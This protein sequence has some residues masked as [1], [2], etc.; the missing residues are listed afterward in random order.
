MSNVRCYP[1]SQI[2]SSWITD[3]IF[4]P[5]ARKLVFTTV[6]RAISYYD[7]NRGSF[8]LTGRVYASG[9]SGH[10]VLPSEKYR[11]CQRNINLGSVQRVQSSRGL[12]GPWAGLRV[13]ESVRTRAY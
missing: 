9:A 10:G 3:G 6:D 13:V 1:C 7:A 4:M 12:C 2:G 8:D 5:V 11:T